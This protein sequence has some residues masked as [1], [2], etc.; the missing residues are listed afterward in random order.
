MLGMKS[1][2]SGGEGGD[3][4]QLG[5]VQAFASPNKSYSLVGMLQA[6]QDCFLALCF[7]FPSVFI[8]LVIFGPKE[9]CVEPRAKLAPQA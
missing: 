5:H 9:Q 7:L 1:T 8:H 2:Q 3:A 6:H 4:V